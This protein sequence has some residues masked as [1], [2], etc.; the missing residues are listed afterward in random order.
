VRVLDS[1]TEGWSRDRRQHLPDFHRKEVQFPESLWV[2]C[3]RQPLQFSFFVYFLIC[4]IL[5]NHLD[6]SYAGRQVVEIAP[7][8]LQPWTGLGRDWTRATKDG[9]ETAGN[10]FQTFVGKRFNFR[11]RFGFPVFVSHCSSPFLCVF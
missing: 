9:A 7:A 10:I 1:S 2:S 6:K 11:S 4:G 8:I 3:F 5:S